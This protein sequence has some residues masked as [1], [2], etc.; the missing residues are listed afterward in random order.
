MKNKTVPFS[1]HLYHPITKKHYYGIKYS[2]GCH[3]DDLWT[4]YFSS[5]KIVKKLIQDYGIDSF[6]FE[7]RKIFKT[8]KEALLWENKFLT[9]INAAKNPNWLN[10]HNGGKK[11]RSPLTQTEIQKIIVSKRFKNVPKSE[12]QKRKMSI[13]AVRSNN[14]RHNSGWRMPKKSLE[15]MIETRKQNI[16][17]GNINPYSIERNKKMAESK[18]GKKRK[19][20]PNGKF[21]MVNKEDL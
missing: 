9:K 4:K 11:F 16:I 8:P 18:T 1:Y 17:F 14:K 5:S 2:K 21:I 20:L 7:V 6:T 3:P 12:E 15:Q 13:S 10:R 19:Y